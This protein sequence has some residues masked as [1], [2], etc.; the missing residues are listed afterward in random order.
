MNRKQYIWILLLPMLLIL[1][2]GEEEIP[3]DL[4]PDPS[5]LIVVEG[6][7]TNE[8]KVHEVTITRPML[9]PNGDPEMV[10]GALVSIFWDTNSVR[11]REQEPGFYRTGPNARAVFGRVYT[12]FIFYQ[13]R[14][15]FATTWMVPVTPLDQLR[16]RKADGQEN[17]YTL[18]LSASEEPSM[19]EIHL[20]WSHLPAF[21]GMP[22]EDTHARIVYYTVNSI[23]VNE[24]F[25][26]A[27]EVVYFPAGTKIMRKKYSISDA[28][29]EFIRTLM[30]ETEW[31][32]G[33][34]D[35]QPGNVKTNLSEG[36]IGYFSAST[37]VADSSVIMPI[38]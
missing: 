30:A 10:S 20:D 24:M 16:Y 32:G 7:I 11:L 37:V 35:V 19:V 29:Q 18:N 13:G 22:D 27:K 28:Q 2:C 26:P 3:W 15:Y 5:S 8:R 17:W 1:A 4:E 38:P 25:K 33:G 36:A 12:L 21:R 9:D 34:F 6:M 14:E 23:D 31:R